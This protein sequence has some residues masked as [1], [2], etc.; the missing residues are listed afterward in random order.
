MLKLIFNVGIFEYLIHDFIFYLK[1]AIKLVTS[2]TR[3]IKLYRCNKLIE[4]GSKNH[5]KIM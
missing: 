2:Y 5:F 1:I 3:D 4:I